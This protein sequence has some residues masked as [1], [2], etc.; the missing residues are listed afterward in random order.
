MEP[1]ENTQTPE[2]VSAPVY[3]EVPSS[4]YHKLKY[5]VFVV[6]VLFA[7]FSGG[8]YFNSSLS[9][10]PNIKSNTQ[11]TFIPT[12][13]VSPQ[14]ISPTPES[15]EMVGW[16]MYKNEKYKFSFSYPKNMNFIEN[17]SSWEGIGLLLQLGDNIKITV[18]DPKIQREEIL[19]NWSNYENIRVGNTNAYLE[20]STTSSIAGNLPYLKTHQ[21][22]IDMPNFNVFIVFNEN[23]EGDFD[24]NRPIFDQILS[25]FEFT[26][27]I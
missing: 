9:K 27:N 6:F 4:N 7:G 19:R 2:E 10:V 8:I 16:K 11:N 15:D 20:T 18:R 3:N 22:L 13:T 24:K 25:T 5:V 23:Q 21:Y 12:P 1:N 17:Q 26:I 14:V